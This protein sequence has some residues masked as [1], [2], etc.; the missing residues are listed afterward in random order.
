MWGR[1]RRYF[2]S[3]RLKQAQLRLQYFPFIRLEGITRSSCMK[4]NSISIFTNYYRK[5]CLLHVRYNCSWSFSWKSKHELGRWKHSALLVNT[6]GDLVY[7]RL[8]AE[9]SYRSPKF[10][11]SDLFPRKPSLH[12]SSF[13]WILTVENCAE[14]SKVCI[15]T[16]R[17]AQTFSV[18]FLTS[19]EQVYK[20][21]RKNKSFYKFLNGSRHGVR[22]EVKNEELKRGK[23]FTTERFDATHL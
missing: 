5:S 16:N 1:T 23:P 2:R 17:R 21:G 8:D 12:Y 4:E 18:A 7:I 14:L 22:T 11:A 20:I 13:I 6:L 15:A 10:S 9:L 19:R 3:N